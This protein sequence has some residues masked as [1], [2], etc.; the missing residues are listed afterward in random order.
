MVSNRISWAYISLST[1]KKRREKGSE[2]KRKQENKKEKETPYR[3]DVSVSDSV[4]KYI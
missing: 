2:E 4:S 1:A 3:I